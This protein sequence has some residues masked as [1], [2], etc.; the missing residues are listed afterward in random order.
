MIL[1]RSA[2]RWCCPLRV[3]VRVGHKGLVV[4]G[5]KNAMLLLI[6]GD[7]QDKIVVEKGTNPLGLCAL[8][9]LRFTRGAARV[10]GFK[11]P[12]EDVDAV[13]VC[14]SGTST[15]TRKSVWNF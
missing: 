9:K 11:L 2:T 13:Q 12:R 6:N 15:C 14:R 8:A 1:C 5:E 4:A 10:R 7:H 3:A